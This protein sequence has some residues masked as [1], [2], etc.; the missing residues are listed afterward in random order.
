MIEYTAPRPSRGARREFRLI[1]TI[2]DPDDV[3][4]VELAAAY[5]QRW[6]YEISL[7]EIETQMLKPGGGLRS[8]S[9]S[10]SGRNYGACC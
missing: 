4:A 2:M 10:S 6:E 8:K 7:R 1:T 3:T 5:A 9:P